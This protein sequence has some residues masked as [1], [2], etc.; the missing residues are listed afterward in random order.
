MARERVEGVDLGHGIR[1][2]GHGLVR[3]PC[4]YEKV[5][6][7]EAT[8]SAAA[9]SFHA[10]HVKERRRVAVGRSVEVGSKSGTERISAHL[11]PAPYVSASL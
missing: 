2:D 10:R 4:L 11:D 3:S 6:A 7:R 5:V 1:Q 9:F 8:S